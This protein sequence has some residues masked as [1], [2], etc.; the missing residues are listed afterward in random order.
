[1]CACLIKENNL[2]YMIYFKME[3]VCSVWT[4]SI[5]FISVGHKVLKLDFKNS[6]EI[7]LL[8]MKIFIY[9][10]SVKIFLGPLYMH[11]GP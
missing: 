9:I 11:N 10:I 1:M 4:Y 3:L 5:Y 6:A 8:N 2:E 7:L